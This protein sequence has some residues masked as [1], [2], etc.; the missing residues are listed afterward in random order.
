MEDLRS[1]APE[2]ASVRE[3]G[4]RLGSHPDTSTPTPACR[5][6][7]LLR[8]LRDAYTPLHHGDTET[9]R[10]PCSCSVFPLKFSEFSVPPW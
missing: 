3:E 8:V 6:G 1:T 7:G 10:N 9:R 4:R 5:T 2:S